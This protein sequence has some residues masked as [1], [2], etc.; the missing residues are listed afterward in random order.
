MFSFFSIKDFLLGLILGLF[1]GGIFTFIFIPRT[2]EGKIIETKVPIVT[3]KVITNRQTD[4]QYIPKTIYIDSKTGQVITEPT[5]VELNSSPEKV[6]V[7]VNGQPYDFTLLQNE[8]QGFQAGKVVLNQS[9]EIDF[10]I[11]TEKIIIDNTRN[12]GVGVGY[13]NNGL[14]GIISVPLVKP[15]LGLFVYG[16]NKT[17]SGGLEFKF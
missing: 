17:I 4:I 8:T 6:N 9:S 5:D 3:E 12:F 13:G 11:K 14:S 10:N 1:L 15:G 2:I 7:K 16:D